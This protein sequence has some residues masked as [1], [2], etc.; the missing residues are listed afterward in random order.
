[1]RDKGLPYRK[2]ERPE[3]VAEGI[4]YVTDDFNYDLDGDNYKMFV[5]FKNFKPQKIKSK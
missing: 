3:N 4:I 5:K 2:A 1:M